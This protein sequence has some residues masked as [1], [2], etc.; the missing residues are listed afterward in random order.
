MG[1]PTINPVR[2]IA[3]GARLSPNFFNMEAAITAVLP[4][5]SSN[6]PKAVPNTIIKPNDFNMFPNPS[7]IVAITSLNGKCIPSPT[8]KQAKNKAKK[9][10]TLNL[11]V[12]KTMRAIPAIRK[13]SIYGKELIMVIICS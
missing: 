12:S 11:V 4:V 8:N 5:Y 2:L 6:K 3:I 13:V 10:G 9:A 7:F 1:N